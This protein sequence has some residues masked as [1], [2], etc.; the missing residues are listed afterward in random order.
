MKDQDL[1]VLL[2]K[3]GYKVTTQRLAIYN[4]IISRKDHPTI[5]QLHEAMKRKFPMISLGTVYK[6]L[7]LLNKL[8]LIQELGFSEG[9][10]RFDPNTKI[11]INMVCTECGKIIDYDSESLTSF[12]RK[13]ISNLKVKPKGQRI[14]LYYKCDD[15]SYTK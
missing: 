13:L 2:R 4:F 5:D 3:K 8:G 11:H 15:C 6:S 9:S 7:H 14:D 12:W 1:I 10:I